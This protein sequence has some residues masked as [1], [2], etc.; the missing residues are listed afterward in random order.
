M[1][2]QPNQTEL[3]NELHKRY[4]ASLVLWCERYVGNRSEL[5]HY[6]EDIVQEAFC[7]ALKKEDSFLSRDNQYGW[8]VYACKN[9]ANREIEKKQA[10]NN[11][12]TL[13]IDALDV[14]EPQDYESRVEIWHDR[15]QAKE[16]LTKIASML[17]DAQKKI[18]DDYFVNEMQAKTVA[19]KH[20][21]KTGAVKSHIEKIRKKGK[22][23]RKKE[24]L[25]IIFFLV[26]SFWS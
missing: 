22:A 18:F 2:V 21:I 20:G 16:T 26:V 4:F 8:L 15:E 14:A 9:V 24:N 23:F 25:G 19:Q 17:T 13:H 3:F 1:A 11:H 7:R 6:A 10:R 12:V 5:R